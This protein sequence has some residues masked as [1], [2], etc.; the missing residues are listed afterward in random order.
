MLR[1]DVPSD[2]GHNLE[3]NS[4]RFRVILELFNGYEP[5]VA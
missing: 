3:G 5:D 2:I 4:I 1:L